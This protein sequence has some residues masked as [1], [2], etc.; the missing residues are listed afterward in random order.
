MSVACLLKTITISANDKSSN[1]GVSLFMSNYL[2]HWKL[3][4]QQ[5]KQEWGSIKKKRKESGEICLFF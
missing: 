1:N 2:K 3:Q 4:Q 5:N